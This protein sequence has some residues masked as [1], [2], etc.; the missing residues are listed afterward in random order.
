MVV[1]GGRRGNATKSQL[2]RDGVCGGQKAKEGRDAVANGNV[3]AG[4]GGKGAQQRAPMY[5]MPQNNGTE[6]VPRLI[7]PFLAYAAFPA[8]Q[9][10]ISMLP[11]SLAAARDS[12]ISKADTLHK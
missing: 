3:S 6:C 10:S 11:P 8:L 4:E 7:Q 1:D 12:A 2:K 9:S 5:G